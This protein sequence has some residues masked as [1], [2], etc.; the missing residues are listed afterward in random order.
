MSNRL[1]NFSAAILLLAAG[2]AV[3]ANALQNGFLWDDQT[4]VVKNIIIRSWE[5]LPAIF[6]S[7]TFYNGGA[8]LSGSVQRG[9]ARSGSE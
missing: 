7:S 8:S 6:A 5:N 3:N 9:S 1:K 4:Q 2:F